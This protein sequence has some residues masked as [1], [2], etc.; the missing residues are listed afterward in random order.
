MRGAF[1]K[2]DKS[3][4]NSQTILIESLQTC[5][6]FN[7]PRKYVLQGFVLETYDQWEPQYWRKNCFVLFEISS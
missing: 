4:W 1:E 2:Q 5:F 7:Q 3:S 6:S